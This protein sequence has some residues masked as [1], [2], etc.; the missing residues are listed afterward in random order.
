MTALNAEQLTDA[1]QGFGNFQGYLDFRALQAGHVV[2]IR[3]L[4]DVAGTDDNVSFNPVT[5][6][7]EDLAEA[8]EGGIE[9]PFNLEAL[10]TGQIGVEVVAG[11]VPLSIP[12]RVTNL[13]TGA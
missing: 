10:Q 2:K 6:A 11:A 5:L 8:G 13:Q 9:L 4:L 3:Q 12:Y 1:V 7:F